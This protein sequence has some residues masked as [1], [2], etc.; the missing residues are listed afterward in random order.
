MDTTMIVIGVA[1]GSGSGKTSFCTALAQCLKHKHVKLLSTDNYYKKVKP[2]TKAPY[3][4]KLYDDYDHPDSLDFDSMYHDFM[5]LIASYEFVIIEGLM[6]LYFEE[7]RKHLD[8]KI[9][10]DCPS[11]ERLI[12][13]LKRDIHEE[14]F[15]EISAEYLDLVRHRHYEF[16]EP[17]RWF[18]DIVVNGSN[19][20]QALEVVEK[21]INSE[22]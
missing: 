4:E 9:Y 7:I 8:L 5:K 18:A 11:D 20:D 13:R 3:R 22:H 10:I 6:V 15:E 17:T 16:V 21:W 12:R 2:K 14:T 19:T 1:G